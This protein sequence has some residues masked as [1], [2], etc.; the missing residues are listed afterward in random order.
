MANNLMDIS[1]SGVETEDANYTLTALGTDMYAY[2]NAEASVSD[3]D[4]SDGLTEITQGELWVQ[5]SPT[6]GG[7]LYIVNGGTEA[8]DF[9]V[10]AINAHA[11]FA[12]LAAL[13]SLFYAVL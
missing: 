11:L 4:S 8:G 13:L 10:D 3:L 12:G 9:T 7:Y 1:T 6:V 2:W 5:E